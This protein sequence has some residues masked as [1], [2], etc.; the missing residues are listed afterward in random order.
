MRGE[1]EVC[2]L[3]S[4]SSGNCFYIGNGKG[5]VLIDAGISAKQICIRMIE[6]GL[7][8]EK[9][10]GIFVTHEH[11]DHVRGADVF[12]RNFN[13]PVFATKGT[14]KSCFLCG[15]SNQIKIIRNTEEVVLVGML[16]EAFGKV[17][18]ALEPVSYTVSSGKKRVSVITDLGHACKSVQ[19][20]VSDADFLFLESNHDEQMLKDGG[21]PYHLKKLI[22]SDEGHLSNRQAGLCV[23]EHAS[24]RLQRVVLSHL[25][26]NNNTTQIAMKTFLKLV[27]ERSDFNFETSLSLRDEA[28]EVWKI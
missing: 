18:D 4:G 22:L 10:K 21:Y 1:L 9:V 2:A 5:G 20:Q 28:T 7:N 24:R 27:K 25:S 8:P 19:E 13:I 11:I 16:I 3:S 17:H 15:E 12:A 26:E 23:L 6:R 14:A